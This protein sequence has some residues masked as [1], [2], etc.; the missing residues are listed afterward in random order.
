MSIRITSTGGEIARFSKLARLPELRRAGWDTRQLVELTRTVQQILMNFERA[1]RN[2][3]AFQVD[4]CDEH[5]ERKDQLFEIDRT[6]KEM[7][8]F[9]RPGPARVMAE[10]PAV[11]GRGLTEYYFDHGDELDLTVRVPA[12]TSVIDRAI[13][14]TRNYY[15]VERGMELDAE[16]LRASL[17]P[18]INRTGIELIKSRFEFCVLR[19]LVPPVREIEQAVDNLVAGVAKKLGSADL[20][21]GEVNSWTLVARLA[22]FGTLARKLNCPVAAMKSQDLLTGEAGRE[23]ATVELLQSLEGEGSFEHFQEHPLEFQHQLTRAAAGYNFYFN[24][25]LEVFSFFYDEVRI[26]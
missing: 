22:M 12:D 21:A 5:G 25:L 18:I 9:L 11:M 15:A 10:V 8:I 20:K 2:R 4:I 3:A 14:A 24:A 13:E 16:E 23:L 19:P 7:F 1:V 17:T 6:A 26:V